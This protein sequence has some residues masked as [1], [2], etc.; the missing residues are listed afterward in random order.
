MIS[1]LLL[2]FAC[3]MEDD[4][5]NE[6]GKDDLT[7][8]KQQQQQ[9]GEVC[10]SLNL[11]MQGVDTRS[12]DDL[13]NGAY[14]DEEK[15]E[16]T[17]DHC[18]IIV[19]ESNSGK[20]ISAQ[21]GIDDFSY[22]PEKG[23]FTSETVKSIFLKTGI[24]YE[25][26]VVANSVQEFKDVKNKADLLPILFGNTLVD[27]ENDL[28]GK[29]K[30]G[31][32]KLIDEE[33]YDESYDTMLAA[34]NNPISVKVELKQLTAQINLK[35]VEFNGFTENTL[36]TDVVLTKVFLNNGKTKAAVSWNGSGEIQI[37]TTGLGNEVENTNETFTTKGDKAEDIA[38]FMTY[39]NSE[40]GNLTSIKLGF[41]VGDTYQE[42]N[43]FII[44]RT[45][46]DDPNFIDD[47]VT[48]YIQAG[49]IYNLHVRVKLVGETIKCVVV[50]YTKDWLTG[51]TMTHEEELDMDVF[52]D[53][54]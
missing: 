17:I 25:M 24:D 34:E 6:I 22:V 7:N 43:D 29:V 20:V 33:Y 26:I 10:L 3:S 39:P 14:D 54:E 8:G 35:E 40:P 47:T 38:S 52:K 9:Q 44:N 31:I 13:A 4:V 11:K 16:D 53:N 19:Y 23:V 30:A 21:D 12:Y 27:G 50:C 15:V 5:L 48:N 1:F 46:N 45:I 28:D 18:S 37:T 32:Y 42:T 49:Y 2:A 36:E 51:E 41:Q